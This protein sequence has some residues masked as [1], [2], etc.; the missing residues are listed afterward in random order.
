MRLTRKQ[1]E[2]NSVPQKMMKPKKA[3]VTK[4]SRADQAD[5]SI[6]GGLPKIHM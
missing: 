2:S 1:H 5:T 3:A 4:Q 6:H